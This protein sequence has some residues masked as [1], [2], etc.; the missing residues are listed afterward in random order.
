[1]GRRSG[2]LLILFA[3]AGC[4]DSRPSAERDVFQCSDGTDD[5][6]D[7]LVDCAD[8]DCA[9]HARCGATDGGG[10]DASIP[11]GT[12]AGPLDATAPPPCSDPLDLVFVI[13]VSTSMTDEIA[14]IRTGIDQVWSAATA[15][16]AN[17]Q[18][19][20]VVFVDDVAAV[21]GCAP[22]AT[23]EA[24]QSELMSWQSFTSSNGQP[25]GSAAS[26]SDCP[27]NSLDAMHVAASLCPWRPSSYRI[28]VHITDDTFEER[29]ARL[30]SVFGTG[31][32]PVQRTYAETV[33]ALRAAQIRVGAFAAPGEGEE[34]GAGSSP[35]VG[36]G[37]HAPYLGMPSIP[38]A[39][40]GDVWSIRDVRAGTIDMA[41]SI[42]GFV[43]TE[44]CTLY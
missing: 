36:R 34:C 26:N 28:L 16:T 7:G 3:M 33:S 24:M 39:T 10:L 4:D 17:A 2:V 18:I 12:D 38:D 19:S 37:F 31:G 35:D 32:I 6:G 8:P 1:M 23:V 30:S 5:D 14:G 43:T 25:G 27:E 29:P 40:G 21:S 11:P 22:F 41:D 44:Y 15:L 20:L 9:V 42:I 13:D